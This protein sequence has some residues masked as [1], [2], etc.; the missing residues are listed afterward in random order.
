MSKDVTLRTL[1]GESRDD[2]MVLRFWAVSHKIPVVS[3]RLRMDPAEVIRRILESA[4]GQGVCDA[5]LAFALELALTTVQDLRRDSSC[6]PAGVT[7]RVT[8]VNA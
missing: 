4:D 1:D 7:V 3:R 6:R 8:V 5:C 2:S